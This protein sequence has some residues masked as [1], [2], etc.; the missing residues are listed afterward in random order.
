MYAV[1]IAHTGYARKRYA[2]IFGRL[3]NA[4][5]SP[6]LE[7]TTLLDQVGQNSAST[8]EVSTKHGHL[9]QLPVEFEMM[10][11]HEMCRNTGKQATTVVC[12][13][14]RQASMLAP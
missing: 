7:S 8:R 5:F 14:N 2:A 13:K 4:V 6:C 9:A 10:T 3:R 1:L 12:N 11:A